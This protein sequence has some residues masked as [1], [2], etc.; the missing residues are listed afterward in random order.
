MRTWLLA[1]RRL[2]ARNGEG[3]DGGARDWKLKGKEKLKGGK[4]DELLVEWT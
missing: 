1:F 4:Q 3:E 2:L